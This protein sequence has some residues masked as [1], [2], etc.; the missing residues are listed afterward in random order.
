MILVILRGCGWICQVG[1]DVPNVSEGR[2]VILVILTGCCRVCQVRD[3]VPNVT[4]IRVVILV[5][6]R[7]CCRV[8]RVRDDVPN[9]GECAVQ[10]RRRRS[11]D[12]MLPAE[13]HTFHCVRSFCPVRVFTVK[14]LGV[15]IV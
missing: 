12:D 3:D 5:I 15:F 7:G 8:C 13:T 2:V 4:E 1:D 14:I 9:V 11:D 6:L 10:Y